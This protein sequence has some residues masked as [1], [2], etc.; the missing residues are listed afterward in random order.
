MTYTEILRSQQL[1]RQV[2]IF[3]TSDRSLDDLDLSG[4]RQIPDPYCLRSS[5]C[6][7]GAVQNALSGTIFVRW[8]CTTYTDPVQHL[9]P[10]G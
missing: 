3:Q 2:E 5:F 10:A 7:M 9:I 6:R 1:T 8:I 4:Q